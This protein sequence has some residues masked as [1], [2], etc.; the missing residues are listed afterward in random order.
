V[1]VYVCMIRRGREICPCRGKG[2]WWIS[3]RFVCMCVCVEMKSY[4]K[5]KGDLPLQREGEVVDFR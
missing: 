4:G 3:G 2:K 5:R 1:C